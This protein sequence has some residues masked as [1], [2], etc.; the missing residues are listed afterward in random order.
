M[1]KQS[2]YYRFPTICDSR[3]VFVCEDDLWTVP[4][5]GGVAVRLTSNLGE[6]S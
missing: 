5:T 3:V 1:S 4:M 6:V 2:G